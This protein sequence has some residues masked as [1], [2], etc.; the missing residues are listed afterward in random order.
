M[1]DFTAQ[2]YGVSQKLRKKTI[3]SVGCFFDRDRQTRKKTSVGRCGIPGWV[4]SQRGR[5]KKRQVGS[6]KKQKKKSARLRQDDKIWATLL[7]HRICR[8]KWCNS[9]FSLVDSGSAGLPAIKPLRLGL[10]LCFTN[11]PVCWSSLVS[12]ERQS[13]TS[14]F[15]VY[16]FAVV[17]LPQ[18]WHEKK[19]SENIQI[20]LLRRRRRYLLHTDG[21]WAWNN[22]K[23]TPKTCRLFLLI[24]IC[25]FFSSSG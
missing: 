8:K 3:A 11:E 16:F 5:P 17:F 20:F 25:F 13:G 2:L 9:F 4:T 7:T 6:N 21:V 10:R 23:T 18:K 14:N 12:I 22:N 24:F 1:S 19:R 15:Y